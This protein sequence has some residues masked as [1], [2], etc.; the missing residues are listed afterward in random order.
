[1]TKPA[2]SRKQRADEK[3]EQAAATD[4][5]T[6]AGREKAAR[7]ITQGNAIKMGRPVPKYAKG[8]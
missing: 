8:N 3:F 4:R 7:L 2:L 6:D 1:M 5:S